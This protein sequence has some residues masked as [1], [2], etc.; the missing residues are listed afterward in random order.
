MSLN[1]EIELGQKM[2]RDA[3]INKRHVDHFFDYFDKGLI[4]LNNVTTKEATKIYDKILKDLELDENKTVVNSV[5][6]LALGRALVLG[7]EALTDQY[8]ESYGELFREYRREMMGI[9]RVKEERIEK[10][11]LKAGVDQDRVTLTDEA[12][13]LMEA[14]NQNGYKEINNM[15]T[16]WVN[17]VYNQFFMGMTKSFTVP[18]LKSLFYNDSGTLKIG[19]SLQEE[20]KNIAAYSLTEQRTAFLR[21]RAK[22]EKMKYCWNS[23]PMDQRTKAE[24]MSASLAGVIPEGQMG[25]NYGFPPRYICR[26]EL[27]YTRP[28]W[29][30]I[31][32]GVNQALEER[33]HRLIR[34]L[35]EAPRQKDAW[36]RLGTL[37]VP[38]DPGRASGRK[39][40]K[41]TATKLVLARKMRVPEWQMRVPEGGVETT[42]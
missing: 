9:V 40:Y 2:V 20:S 30:G 37:V 4:R 11:L 10:R 17:F 5:D 33:R 12:L 28:E 38:R 41:E 36:R 6:N 25:S 29:T 23:N 32:T 1:Q 19:S 16:K 22:E 24:C 31:N 39:M 27:V 8:R 14:I 35:R 7:I 15:L 18:G 13:K 34:E 21:Q 3:E 42:W 26:C